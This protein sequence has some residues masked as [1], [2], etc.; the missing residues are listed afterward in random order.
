M[1]ACLLHNDPTSYRHAE[2]ERIAGPQIE[3]IRRFGRITRII[4]YQ[5]PLVR[6]LVDRAA[7]KN[8]YQTGP[9]TGK[10]RGALQY[11]TCERT[12]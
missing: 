10:G 4:F 9:E 1:T 7:G 5:Y 11:Y 8:S 2:V 3:K 6:H 12:V